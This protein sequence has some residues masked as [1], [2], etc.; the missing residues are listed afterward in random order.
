MNLSGNPFDYLVAF[1]GGIF[2]SFTPCVYPLIPVSVSY[3]GA[4]SSGSKLR[5]FTLSLTYVTGV[6]VTYA[7]LGLAASLTGKIFGAVSTHPL[8]YIITGSV[9]IFF[10]LSMAGF[11]TLKVPN[12]VKLPGLNKQNYFSTFFLGLVSGLIVGP[13]TTPALGAI[14]IYLAAKKNLL[15]GTTL[16]LSFAYGMGLVLILIGT[17]SSALIN[18]LPKSGRWLL[19]IQKISAAVLIGFGLYLAAKGIGRF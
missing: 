16:L 2:I 8:T 12:I 7:V 5:G 10:G 14:L 11:F 1:L 13:C 18:R 9:I 19:Y 3:I 4:K 15:Y 17:F 6:A